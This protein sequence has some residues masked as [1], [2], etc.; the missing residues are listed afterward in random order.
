[1]PLRRLNA[2]LKL[3]DLSGTAAPGDSGRMALRRVLPTEKKIKKSGVSA[4]IAANTIPG[5]TSVVDVSGVIA[6]AI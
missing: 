4:I 5:N 2:L 3:G 1:M 6:K